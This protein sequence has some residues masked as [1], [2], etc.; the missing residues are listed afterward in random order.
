MEIGFLA[1][2]S[3][4]VPKMPGRGDRE[5]K[6]WSLPCGGA[7]WK[8][9]LGRSLWGNGWELEHPWSIRGAVLPVATLDA[10][11]CEDGGA[12]PEGTVAVGRGS[13]VALRFQVLRGR[14]HWREN[15]Q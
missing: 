14:R 4:S 8:G 6:G 13:W 9:R 5:K 3:P 2:C 7:H 10:R 15:I 12:R 1:E 11:G